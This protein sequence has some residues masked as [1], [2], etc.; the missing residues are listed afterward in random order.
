[1]DGHVRLDLDLDPISIPVVLFLACV[2]F[3]DVVKTL[4]CIGVRA[5]SN[6]YNS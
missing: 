3:H 6:L 2:V 4:C 5:P 1:M